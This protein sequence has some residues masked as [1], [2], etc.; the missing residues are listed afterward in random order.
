MGVCDSV[1]SYL[2]RCIWFVASV[3]VYA[4]C[5]EYVSCN[6]CEYVG[7]GYGEH[8][9]VSVTLHMIYLSMWLY[10]LISCA[11][12]MI[13]TICMSMWE[14]SVD[15]EP[16]DLCECVGVGY[17][18]R[19]FVSIIIHMI[20]LSVWLCIFI[21]CALRMIRVICV[22]MCV[23]SVQYVSYD[24]CEHVSVECGACGFYDSSKCAT[25]YVIRV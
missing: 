8:E 15:H 5:V 23:L 19:E 1:C 24:S 3:R 12:R 11:S 6:I 25:L 21:S 7:V 13:R 9:F 2:V 20:D 14:L 16:Y 22:S 10:V 17:G 18:A 4:Y